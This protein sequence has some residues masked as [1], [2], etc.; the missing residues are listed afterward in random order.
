MSQ[1]LDA[2]LERARKLLDDG[3]ADKALELLAP[4][5]SDGA[6]SMDPGRQVAFC[7]LI[8]QSYLILDTPDEAIAPLETA[9]AICEALQQKDAEAHFRQLL[10]AAKRLGERPGGGRTR[11]EQQTDVIN[12]R[13]LLEEG[14]AEQARD[15]LVKLLEEARSVGSRDLEATVLGGLGQALFLLDKPEAAVNSVQ[16]GIEICQQEKDEA[17]ENYL[18]ALLNALEQ[19]DDGRKHNREGPGLASGPEVELHQRIDVALEMAKAGQ[20]DAAL[21]KLWKVLEDA[22]NSGSLGAEATVRLLLG[23]ILLSRDKKAEGKKMLE[24]ALAIAVKVDDK[25]AQGAIKAL[26]NDA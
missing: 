14:E 4:V 12:A 26:L 3:K 10:E 2:A 16:E 13:K 18:K 5:W 24:A 20:P 19:G 17:G 9:L 25:Q 15:I 8:A 23:Q 7:D 6:D 21:A 22:E 1:L 11:S